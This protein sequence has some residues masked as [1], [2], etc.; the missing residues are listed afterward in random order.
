MSRGVTY[1]SGKA[2]QTTGATSNIDTA[3]NTDKILS[4]HVIP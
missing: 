2:V 3:I 4:F 1:K